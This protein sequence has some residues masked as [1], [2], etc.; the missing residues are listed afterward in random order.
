MQ[1]AG[2]HRLR[3][4]GGLARLGGVPR[5]LSRVLTTGRGGPPECAVG[6]LVDVPAGVLLE[7]VVVAALRAA[8]TQ[9]TP[10]AR[11]VGDIVL[12]VLPG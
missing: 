9:A 1:V 4:A 12:E 6:E 8:V 11:L 2:T 10:S 7:P 3:L 5:G